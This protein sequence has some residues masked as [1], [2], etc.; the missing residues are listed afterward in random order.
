LSVLDQ[1]LPPLGN[2]VTNYVIASASNNVSTVLK[3]TRGVSVSDS[4]LLH[5][6]TINKYHNLAK[7]DYDY[8]A[9]GLEDES[10]NVVEEDEDSI[11][12]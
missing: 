6:L 8:A 9:I 11:S 5:I 7:V 1:Y 12:E 3:R 4:Y 2:D 10:E